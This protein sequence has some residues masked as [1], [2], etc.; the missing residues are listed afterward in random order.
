MP[1]SGI[2]VR[3]SGREA[4]Q[5]GKPAGRRRREGDGGVGGCGQTGYRSHYAATVKEAPK[6]LRPG[7]DPPLTRAP[8]TA[9]L[10]ALRIPLHQPLL[11]LPWSLLPTSRGDPSASAAG[12]WPR[13]ARPQSPQNNHGGSCVHVQPCA[14]TRLDADGHSGLLDRVGAALRL[15]GGMDGLVVSMGRKEARH[16]F[17][18]EHGRKRRSQLGGE[19]GRGSPCRSPPP[20]HAAAGPRTLE[21]AG[22]CHP[23]HPA[24]A[25]HTT[26]PLLSAPAVRT[27]ARGCARLSTGP[28]LA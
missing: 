5:G 6:P 11:P 24:T 13:P 18:G 2:C 15:E 14:A 1:N 12:C 10:A 3:R 25:P 21:R 17:G 27:W 4:R 19:Y 8:S 20:R 22:G 28:S 26:A 9:S 7:H 16:R 23:R